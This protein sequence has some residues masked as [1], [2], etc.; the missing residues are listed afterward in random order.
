MVVILPLAAPLEQA[1]EAKKQGYIVLADWA[2]R[3]VTVNDFACNSTTGA[4]S[5]QWS[6]SDYSDSRWDDLDGEERFVI[7]GKF[8]SYR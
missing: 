8:A 6:H 5:A 3:L 2:G 4:W 7:R 1:I